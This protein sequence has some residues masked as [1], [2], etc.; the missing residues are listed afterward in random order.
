MITKAILNEL[1]KIGFVFDKDLTKH[2]NDGEGAE[3]FCKEWQVVVVYTT[4]NSYTI[5]LGNIEQKAHQLFGDY[6][7]A[8]KLER[9]YLHD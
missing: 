3:C 5:C 7:I 2:R 8:L 6:L 4:Q 1:K 9:R